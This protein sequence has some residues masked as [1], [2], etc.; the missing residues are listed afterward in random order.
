MFDHEQRVPEVAKLFERVQQA[1]VVPLVEADGG[2]VEDVENADEAAPD[3]VA[4]RIRWLSPPD[5]VD[6]SR[7]SVRSPV[8]PRS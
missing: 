1:V 3:R 2:L 7:S 8:R 5:S 4:S 6:A